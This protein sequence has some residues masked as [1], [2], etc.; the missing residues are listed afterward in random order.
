[1]STFLIGILVGGRARRLGGIPKGLLPT[2]DTGEPIVVRLAR[3]CREVISDSE[4][5]LV[6]DA[7]DYAHLHY[8]SI[9]DEPPGIGPIGA[10]ASLLSAAARSDRD[11][12]VLAADLPF[13]S[14]RLVER[15][16][17]H[18]P[19]ALAVAPRIDN[20][21]Q[22]LFARYRSVP[23]L[24]T[25]TRIVEKGH[26]ALHRVLSELGSSVAELP[27]TAEEA[28]ELRDWDTPDDV[29]RR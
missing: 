17:T 20:M 26:R 18:A 4:L 29:V 22:P 28:G 19:D 5:V 15:L 11:E 27:L 16:A 1:V 7:R 23:C 24:E 3:I 8:A 14:R 13:V 25:T 2:S 10:L 6:G 21:W 12:I 9:E